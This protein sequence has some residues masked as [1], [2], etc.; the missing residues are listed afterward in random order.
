LIGTLR[1][2][3]RKEFLIMHSENLLEKFREEVQSN[4][5]KM[6]PEPPQIGGLSLNEVLDSDYFF[7]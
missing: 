6:L 4:L 3:I 1:D 2:V 5:G 7:S